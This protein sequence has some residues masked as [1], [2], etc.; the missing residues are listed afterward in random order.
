MK[1][2]HTRGSATIYMADPFAFKRIKMNADDYLSA[3]ETPSLTLN[4]Q[5]YT[6][7]PLSFRSAVKLQK[8]LSSLSGDDQL[9]QLQQF[10]IELCAEVDLP[11][12]E[13]L[14]LPPAVFMKVVEEFFLSLFGAVVPSKPSATR[15]TKQQPKRS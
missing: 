1:S 14:D 2:I 11:A 3:I 6:T 13:I 15:G 4:G 12:D 5:T 8:R 7:K 10:T 9:E